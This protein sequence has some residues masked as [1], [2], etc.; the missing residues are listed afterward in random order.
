MRPG[1]KHA[2][3]AALTV[4]LCTHDRREL[5]ART[6][7]SLDA[8][9]RPAGVAV[10]V[11]VV[12]NACTDDTHAWL[13][14]RAHANAPRLPLRWIAE[15]TPGKSHALNRAFAE[16]LGEV[17]AFVD[18]DHRVDPGY[19]EAVLAAARA[20][21]E[22]G[23][24]CGRILPDWDGREPA[25]VHDEGPYRIY[26]L[27]VPRFDLGDE[28]RE[29]HHDDSVPGG[30]NLV[31]RREVIRATGAFATDLGPTGHD[32]GGAEDLDWVRRALRAGA[33]LR[34][35]PDIVQYHYVD[36]ER[37]RLGYLMRKGYQ[38]S[39]SVMR[40]DR[41]NTEVPLYMWRKLLE[42]LAAVVLSLDGARRRFF[43]VRLASA[44]GELAGLN[45][46]GMEARARGRLPRT[47]R[48]AV[49]AAL[50]AA[51]LACFGLAAWLSAGAAVRAAPPV[52]GAA[53][54]A[55]ALLVLKSLR[56]FSRSGPRIRDEILRRYRGYT[57]YA[58]ARLA[59][60]A[61]AVAA[62]LGGGGALAWAILASALDVPVRTVSLA[63]AAAL[64]MC[65]GLALQFARK[66]HANPGLIVA[67]WQYR[68]SRLADWREAL[69]GRTAHAAGTGLAAAAAALL[70]WA[71]ASLA[72]R[73]AARELGAALAALAG[74]A[75]AIAWA[76]WEPEP[77]PRHPV[78]RAARPNI[79]MIGSDTLRADRILDP[80]YPRRLA[81]NIEALAA[82][83]SFFPN[84][85]VPC[86]RTAP[87]LIS[88]LSGTW[89]HTHGVR[90]NFVAGTDTRLPV[91]M[92]PERLR[93]AGYRTV[94][95]SDWCGADLGKFSF[96]FD[97]AE[98]PQ[99][100]WNLK[101]LIR[102]GPKDL[103]LVLSLFC[104]NR[105]GRA[106]LPEIH[107]QGGVPQTDTLGTRARELLSRLAAT[108]EPFL[109]N[110]FF[111]TTHP[112]FAS[113]APWFERYCEGDYRGES[114]F[115]MARLND[116]FDIIRRQG[117]ART[118]F[119]L[120]QILGLYD[121][122][123]A[124]FDHEVGRLL[125]HLEA[126]G[127][128]QDTILVLYSDHGMEF[129]E[130]GTWG[131]G[132]SAVGDF[133]ARVPLLIADP[134]HPQARRCEQVVRS[135][136]V[137]PTLA[138]LAGCDYAGPEG[139]S[140]RP[141]IEGGHLP[142]GLPAF[143][144]TGIWFTEVPGLP[145]GHLRYPDLFEVLEVADPA[146]GTLGLKPGYAGR[147]I[148]AKDRMIRRGRWKLVCQPLEDGMR[149]QL[150]D[151]AA[152]PGCTRDC[153]AQE[154]ALA[155]ELWRELSRWMEAER[156]P[157]AASPGVRHCTGEQADP[158]HTGASRSS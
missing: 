125:A 109:L 60:W 73:G 19:L 51:A 1:A 155:E 27:P 71:L 116:P 13:E 32:L 74:Y 153:S 6:I 55:S 140:L 103:R 80:A 113:E 139:V 133:S 145:P 65:A 63:A 52:A 16:P 123:V 117:E 121:G 29:L 96:G 93:E 26:P 3:P 119:D 34:Y 142:E 36:L 69:A 82:R 53:A 37:L 126:C 31:A 22:A 151:L 128:S 25:W 11:L 101:Y 77:A 99:D 98:V 38:R 10:E 137:A 141:F 81:P 2:S 105:F 67:A 48:D 9:R 47:A 108:G 89:P 154:P 70:L 39:K 138:E 75:A 62:F 42:Y 95:V 30:G 110:V 17:V 40:L 136:D 49:F 68:L 12:A 146:A 43:L 129:F 83:G 90:D 135:I 157:G 147:V 57:T 97:R 94:A 104:H 50:F 127:L 152:D 134:R 88:L 112:P 156:M 35:A 132:N 79:V 148:A 18:D 84:C 158:M 106:V 8:A 44:L 124:R 41:R 72:A 7:A 24:F 58:F 45:A 46:N 28:A 111:S 76:G 54:A 143:Y 131:Q 20:H 92:L 59:F 100:Q 66:L 78:R 23:L 86:A 102:Q 91:R 114:K 61:W 85:Y 64:G 144:E 5:L 122:C 21:P 120:D 4:L 130:H 87:S 56:D 33:R 115:A 149:L 118:E 150:F 107:F 14:A 15:A